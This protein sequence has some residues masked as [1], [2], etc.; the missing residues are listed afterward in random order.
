MTALQSY[1]AYKDSGVEWLGDVPEHWEVRRLKHWLEINRQVLPEDTDPAYEFDYLDIGSVATGRLT[2]PPKRLRFGGAPSRARRIVAHGDTIVSTVR[3]YLKAVWY[4]KNP[5]ERLI[6]STG[7]AV[8]TP[9]RDAA[10]GFVGYACQSDPFVD[11]VTAESVGIAYPAISE[12][13]F[14]TFSVCVPPLPEQTAIA[15]F[16]DDADRR[17]RRYIRAKERLI[18]LLEEERRATIHEAVTG[19]IDVRTGQ[20]YPAYKDSGVEWLGRVPEHWEVIRARYVF[21]EI[22]RRS[23]Y[24]LEQHLSMSQELGLV[25]SHLVK[26]RT[27]VSE[28]YA[29]GKLCD[30]DDLVLNRLKAHLGV[31]A[32]ARNQGIVSPDY[33][34]LRLKK[35][36]A[37]EFFERVLRSSGCR[38]E[39]RIRA[40]GIVEGF[41][42][43]YTDDFNEIKIPV[44]PVEEQIAIA[45]FLAA[46]GR[47]LSARRATVARQ[48]DLLREYRT[49]LI[50][51]V[52]TGKLDVREAATSLPEIGPDRHRPRPARHDPHRVQPTFDRTRH[53]EG[54]HDMTDWNECPAVERTPGKV[55]GAWVFSGTRIPLFAL[56]ENLA[57]GATVE[58]FV[59]WFPGVEERQVRAV[60]E[61]EAN[62][63]RTALAR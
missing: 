52:V 39:L 33:T 6:A 47:H 60:L 57:S 56:Y 36:G 45:D 22:D 58:E 4:A 40:K 26:N 35:A 30:I 37:M 62:T 12:T 7:F 61:H 43:L 17:I 63:L 42:R 20:P 9:D 14:A 11:R 10:P 5:E 51:D 48:I 1:P 46:A 44:P 15:R 38:R 41:W 54:G 55:S 28:S 49:R 18:E 23:R 13:R 34:V 16:L 21:R 3:T 2:E 24:G 19:R 8:L 59:E 32:L 31:F 53:D 29:G 27:L 50:A 25:P